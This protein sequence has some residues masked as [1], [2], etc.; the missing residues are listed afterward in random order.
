MCDQWHIVCG[1]IELFEQYQNDFLEIY[2]KA[3]TAPPYEN[4]YLDVKEQCLWLISMFND[5][6]AKLYGCIYQDR[7]VGFMLIAPSLYDSRLPKNVRALVDLSQTISIAELAVDPKIRHQGIA[8][9]F[10]SLFLKDMQ[11]H[12]QD[13]VIVRT[14]ANADAAIHLYK[15][16]H[17]SEMAR[18]SIKNRILCDNHIK[19]ILSNKILFT[20]YI[21]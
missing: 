12:S 20:K 4:Q 2:M 3:F 1:G 9:Q 13:R 10:V 6:S 11:A 19:G 21:H 8:T 15:K 5:W 16:F 17:F 7:M 18:F 14:N